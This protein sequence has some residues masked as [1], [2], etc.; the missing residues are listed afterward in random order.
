ML[1]HR[2]SPFWLERTSPWHQRHGFD[3]AHRVSHITECA[4]LDVVP[5]QGCSLFAGPFAARR[6][7]GLTQQSVHHL[8]DE[9]VSKG[10]HTS[11]N[12]AVHGP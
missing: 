5:T 8:P 11:T 10:F 3:L 4:L 9:Q 6:V 2:G 7:P 1:G 12:P